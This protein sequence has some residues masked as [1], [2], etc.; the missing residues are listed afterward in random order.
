M[1]GNVCIFCVRPF[2][3][4]FYYVVSLRLVIFLYNIEILSCRLFSFRYTEPLI[5][6]QIT[7]LIIVSDILFL[8]DSTCSDGLAPVQK[9]RSV[10]PA[11]GPPWSC[12]IYVSPLDS[13]KGISF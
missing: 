7:V 12:V 9:V 3:R 10:R 6:K 8:N 1:L 5:N 2:S 13:N 4:H 11:Q